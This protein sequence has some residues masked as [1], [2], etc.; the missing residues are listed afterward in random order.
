MTGDDLVA[1]F[2][3]M[4]GGKGHQYELRWLYAGADET[5]I[6]KG[7]GS[8]KLILKEL[9]RDTLAS[10]RVSYFAIHVDG[11]RVAEHFVTGTTEVKLHFGSGSCTSSIWM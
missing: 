3:A 5:T 2:A 11:A 9:L 4:P 1:L 8:S 10:G 7:K 6:H